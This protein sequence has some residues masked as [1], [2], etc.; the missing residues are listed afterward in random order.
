MLKIGLFHQASETIRNADSS[1]TGQSN[2]F[3]WLDAFIFR[4]TNQH[5]HSIRSPAGVKPHLRFRDEIICLLKILGI[6]DPM[7]V[8]GKY[9]GSIKIQC[10]LRP[11]SMMFQTR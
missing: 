8:H 9:I 10:I 5:H 3:V 11:Q 7:K 2:I 4:I 1:I 6:I